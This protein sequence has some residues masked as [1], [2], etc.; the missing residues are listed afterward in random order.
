MS[1]RYYIKG[2]TTADQVELA[3][4]EKEWLRL[5]TRKIFA[6]HF[7][8]IEQ[9]YN[10]L[11]E[12]YISFEKSLLTHTVDYQIRRYDL[13][14]DFKFGTVPIQ[15]KIL[16]LIL[17][18]SLFYDQTN[19]RHLKGLK[20]TNDDIATLIN[21]FN[22]EKSSNNDLKFLINLRNYSAHKD[23]PIDSFTYANKWEREDDR[24]L[25]RLGH[26]LI[27]TISI[28][29]LRSDK[30]FNKT[31]LSNVNSNQKGQIDLRTPIR[32]VIALF[33][34]FMV[35]LRKELKK[36][37][38]EVETVFNDFIMRFKKYSNTD[39]DFFKVYEEVD[40]KTVSEYFIN[41]DQIKIIYEYS[42]INPSQGILEKR[43]IHNRA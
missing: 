13:K 28:N 17:S 29:K 21:Q 38:S 8:S 34:K 26:V 1:H 33:S 30:N 42:K 4:D 11:I 7:S 16:N 10:L 3:L 39:N 31:V 35:E 5:I 6:D 41:I 24:E 43:Y 19:K 32:K 2:L 25:D 18:I 22:R 15:C 20:D 12:N 37:L 40:G 14:H 23:I 27:P 36:E 9:K